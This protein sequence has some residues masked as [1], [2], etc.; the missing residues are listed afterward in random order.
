MLSIVNIVLCD[1][2]FGYVK[3]PYKMLCVAELKD[4]GVHKKEFMYRFEPLFEEGQCYIIS[5]FG[6]AENGGKLPLLPHMFN[7]SFY[8]N[9]TVTRVEPFDNNTHGFIF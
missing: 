7:I 5:N 4:P 2:I 6:I 1:S 8:G 9:T 3:L